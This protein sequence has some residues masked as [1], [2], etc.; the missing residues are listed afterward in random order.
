MPANSELLSQ[1]TMLGRLFRQQ[2]IRPQEVI[3]KVNAGKI[4]ALILLIMIA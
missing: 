4:F 3:Q 2:A 1:G